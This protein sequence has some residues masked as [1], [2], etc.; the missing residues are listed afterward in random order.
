MDATLLTAQTLFE[1]LG[2]AL[3]L[4]WLAGRQGAAR[5]LNSARCPWGGA[6]LVSHLSLINPC[7]VQVIGT[8][9]RDYLD[10][11]PAADRAES[12]Q[13]LF[14][15]AE[16]VILADGLPC[17]PALRA[18]ADARDVP[19][20][21][22]PVAG[23]ELV[24]HLRYYLS[25]ALAERTTVHGVLMEVLGTGVLL[26]GASNVGKSELALELITRGHRL[27]AD[28]APEL[29]RITPNTLQ[30]RCP[31]VLQ[32]MLE[33]RGLGVLNVRAMYG[34]NALKDKKNLRLIIDLQHA[35]PP[36]DD[37]ARLQGT[38]SERSLLGIKVP[39]IVIHVAPSR[40]LAVLVEAAVRNHLLRQSGYDA[41]DDL[42]RRQMRLIE[43]QRT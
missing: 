8:E 1:A 12:I 15:S 22:S 38:L 19:L 23:Q 43:A 41:A 27:V 39:V 18:A 26:V 36:A 30:G 32:D 11:L 37:V 7:E 34:D 21:A 25:E 4:D 5:I 24:S 31:A 10:K 17:P 29:A 14:Q 16:L 40:N 20:F 6:A 28:D 3:R 33:V 13:Q 35:E 42:T 9:E 2:D